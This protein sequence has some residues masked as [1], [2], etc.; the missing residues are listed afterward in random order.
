MDLIAEFRAEAGPEHQGLITDLF[1]KI[2]L[3][4]V[5]VTDAQVTKVGD[6]F[7]FSGA[8]SLTE[9]TASLILDDGAVFYLNGQE[10]YRHNMPAGPVTHDTPAASEVDPVRRHLKR[11]G[12]ESWVIGEIHKG[13]GQVILP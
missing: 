7:D 9:L 8:T 10:V 5:S 2:T 1:E 6:E 3:F 4:D 12:E 13:K 11:S